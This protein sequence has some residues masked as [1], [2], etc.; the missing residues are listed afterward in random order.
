M[1]F[2]RSDYELLYR[3]PRFMRR[4]PMADPKREVH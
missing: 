1:Q 2:F 4:P 3:H